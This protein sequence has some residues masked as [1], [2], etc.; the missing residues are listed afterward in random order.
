VKTGGV[1]GMGDPEDVMGS[2]SSGVVTMIVTGAFADFSKIIEELA[3]L[4][5]RCL[6]GGRGGGDGR[7]EW[8][9]GCTE[10]L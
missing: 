5:F 4:L 6:S 8:I 1:G 9:V 3:E 2:S 10:R 7:F